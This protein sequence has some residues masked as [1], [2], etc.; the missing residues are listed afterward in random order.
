MGD[1]VFG[2]QPIV[3]RG[4]NLV[5]GGE[6]SM[7][8][9][10]S[11]Q[12][13]YCWLLPRLHS[14]QSYLRKAGGIQSC[15]QNFLDL[16]IYVAIIC[17]GGFFAAALRLLKRFHDSSRLLGFPTGLW[18]WIHVPSSIEFIVDCASSNRLFFSKK[19]IARL[20]PFLCSCVGRIF[21]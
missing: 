20:R 15:V 16:N 17:V 11:P 7:N 13:S 1:I 21:C 8:A 14:V 10:V 9:A 3:R 19:L 5:I 4:R 6:S 12:D 2:F 18:R